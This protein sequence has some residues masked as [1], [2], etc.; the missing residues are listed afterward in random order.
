MTLSWSG[1]HLVDNTM[2]LSTFI[3]WVLLHQAAPVRG[4]KIVRA[5]GI[6]TLTWWLAKH[7]RELYENITCT[8]G[9]ACQFCGKCAPSPPLRHARRSADDPIYRQRCKSS[10][11]AGEQCKYGRGTCE[12]LQPKIGRA[13]AG[14]AMV[15]QFT[16][17]ADFRGMTHTIFLEHLI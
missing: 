11:R 2:K 9:D 12:I 13:C 5:G 8:Y 16:A 7:E 4:W 1:V 14:Y 17:R 10:D 6:S 15:R 3:L